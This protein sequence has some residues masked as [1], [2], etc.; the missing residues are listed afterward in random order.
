VSWPKSVLLAGAVLIFLVAPVVGDQ[1]ALRI[2]MGIA[3]LWFLIGPGMGYA[4][5]FAGQIGLK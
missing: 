3:V 5:K 1:T 4:E 2:T